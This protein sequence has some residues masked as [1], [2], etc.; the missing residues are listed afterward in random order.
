MCTSLVLT[1][2][3]VFLLEHGHTHQ[4]HLHTYKVTCHCRPPTPEKITACINRAPMQ[5]YLLQ[6]SLRLMYFL[7]GLFSIIRIYTSGNLQYSVQLVIPEGSSPSW[8]VSCAYNV[9]LLRVY[10]IM[11]VQFVLQ[12]R[13]QLRVQKQL[14]GSSW[15]LRTRCVLGKLRYLSKIRVL[16]SG[17][18]IQTLDFE[19]F[20]TAHRPSA[21]AI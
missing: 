1:A 15:F 14:Y 17:T 2:Q 3:A 20:A 10:S 12:H 6:C 19:N 21:S 18:S 7:T 8:S 11:D 16:L 5:F 13:K 4:T 9:P